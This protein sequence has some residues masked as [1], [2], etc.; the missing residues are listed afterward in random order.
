MDKPHIIIGILLFALVTAILYVWGLRK[1]EGQSEDL[2]RILLNRCGNK[3]VKY[4]KKHKTITEAE[5]ARQID[6]ITASEFWSKKRLK[7]QQP[8]K[9]AKQVVAFLIDQQYIESAGQ[10]GYRLK[11]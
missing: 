10:D 7:V 3:V 4:L 11:K 6:G 8:K 5:V 9:F 1:S 2:S